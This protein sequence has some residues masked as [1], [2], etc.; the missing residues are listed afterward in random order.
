MMKKISSIL[1][2]CI[3]AIGVN[4]QI[5]TPNPKLF[6]ESA[7][8][9]DSIKS[10]SIKSSYSKTTV[11]NNAGLTYKN[12]NPEEIVFY[13]P[14]VNKEYEIELISYEYRTNPPTRSDQKHISNWTK[15]LH[16]IYNTIHVKNEN[17]VISV[18]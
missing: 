15:S 16:K 10:V 12:N 17:G 18:Y 8:M 7:V 9:N 3:G 2:L 1:L 4:A 14:A 13:V 11:S 5:N 6:I